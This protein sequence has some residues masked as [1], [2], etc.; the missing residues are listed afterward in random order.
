MSLQGFMFF[1]VISQLEAAVE[2]LSSKV[3]DVDVRFL[4]LDFSLISG[5]DVCSSYSIFY[6]VGL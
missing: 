1:G 5:V 6:N 4:V 2:K 3:K